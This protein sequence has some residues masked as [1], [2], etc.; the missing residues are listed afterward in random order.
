MSEWIKGNSTL[1]MGVLSLFLFILGF[2]LDIQST[3]VTQ[4]RFYHYN[5]EQ[6]NTSKRIMNE[7]M[8]VSR[9]VSTNRANIASN[10]AKLDMII[11]HAK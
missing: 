8:L 1:I 3:Y 10:T 2:A 9:M 5:G 4:E 6:D 11:N 7:L